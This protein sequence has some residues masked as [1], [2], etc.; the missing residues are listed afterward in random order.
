MRRA[1][2]PLAALLVV[3]AGCS[4]LGTDVEE[5]TPT[6]T[7]APVPTETAAAYPFGVGPDGVTRPLAVANAHAAATADAYAFRS[8]WTV[9]RADGS[10]RERVVLRGRVRPE[11]WRTRVAVTGASPTVLSD[12]PATAVFWSN[13]TVLVGKR[14]GGGETRYQYVP[15]PAYT[16]SGFFGRIQRPY[17]DQTLD[18]L[19]GSLDLRVVDERENGVVLAG[20][21]VVDRDRFETAVPGRDPANVSYRLFVDSEGVVRDQRLSY[22]ATYRGERVSVVRRV[23]YVAVE[24]VSVE[25]PE[26]YERAVEEGG[27]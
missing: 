23:R 8:N 3:L 12:R 4:G 9:R 17:P 22:E 11:Q 10:V 7:P 24:N 2:L 13:R 19:L 27:L 6:A 5:P 14:V 21:T 18:F 1:V 26:W 25:R 16:E 15:P 20:D